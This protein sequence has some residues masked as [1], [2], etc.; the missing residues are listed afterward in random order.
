MGIAQSHRDSRDGDLNDHTIAVITTRP[1]VT[2]QKVVARYH[3]W[4]RGL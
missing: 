2:G 1:Q 3:H 4:N